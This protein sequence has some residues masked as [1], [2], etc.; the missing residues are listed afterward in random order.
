VRL[1][2]QYGNI[3]QAED[4]AEKLRVL[5]I[6]THISSKNSYGISRASTGAIKV[7][8]WA[9]LD[10][11]YKDACSVLTK[12]K[13][14]VTSGLSEEELMKMESE[15]KEA[16]VKFFNGILIKVGFSVAIVIGVLLYAY[17]KIS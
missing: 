6:L 12:S 15:A 11:Q 5:G 1:I 7:G 14:V 17:S 3:V 8:L 16:S 9:V 10:F 4:A 13:H 2:E